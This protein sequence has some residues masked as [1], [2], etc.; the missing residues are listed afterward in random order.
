MLPIKH[1][2]YKR[3][4][5]ERLS[6]MYKTDIFVDNH[7]WLNTSKI[8]S[9]RSQSTQADKLNR[10]RSCSVIRTENS[11]VCKVQ[12]TQHFV[13]PCNKSK[14][15]NNC[16]NQRKSYE[17]DFTMSSQQELEIICSPVIKYTQFSKVLIIL[18]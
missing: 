16:C 15:R 6:T 3:I 7:D 12:N 2:R 11:S 5:M 17:R 10:K 14:L 1:S 13:Y 18:P 4:W 8:Y 9:Y